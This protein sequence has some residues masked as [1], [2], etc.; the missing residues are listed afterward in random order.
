ML[1]AKGM[2]AKVDGEWNHECKST[3]ANQNE[4]PKRY[5][6]QLCQKKGKREWSRRKMAWMVGADL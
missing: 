5:L 4:A 6:I 3:R 2:D 1:P